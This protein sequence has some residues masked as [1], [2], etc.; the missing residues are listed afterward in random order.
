MSQVREEQEEIANKDTI[1][2]AITINIINIVVK[3]VA[4]R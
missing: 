3:F 2:M 1:S 4:R